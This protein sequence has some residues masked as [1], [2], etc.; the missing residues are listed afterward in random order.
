MS[1][2]GCF[3][4]CTVEADNVTVLGDK[5]KDEARSAAATEP[6]TIFPEF[7][8]LGLSLSADTELF[9]ILSSVTALS[10]IPLDVILVKGID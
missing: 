7:I 5:S 6:S 3:N 4:A 2:T 10:A 9:V 8:E 1:F